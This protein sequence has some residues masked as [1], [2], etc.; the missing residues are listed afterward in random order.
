MAA[1]WGLLICTAVVKWGEMSRNMAVFGAI[2]GRQNS[3]N[4]T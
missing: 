1:K 4:S 2:L 3:R